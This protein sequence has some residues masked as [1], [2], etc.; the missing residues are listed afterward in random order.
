MFCISVQT[1]NV[2]EILTSEK[3]DHENVDQ[4]QEL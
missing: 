1:F 3:F 2:S 4:G